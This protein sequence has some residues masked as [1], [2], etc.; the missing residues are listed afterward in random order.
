MAHVR[1]A[2]FQMDARDS[3]CG[4][5]EGVLYFRWL[6]GMVGVAYGVSTIS[7]RLAILFHMR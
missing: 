1:C 3:G 7:W 5:C 4:A 2:L 6:H